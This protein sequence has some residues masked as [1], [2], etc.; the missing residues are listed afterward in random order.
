MLDISNAVNGIVIHQ[1]LQLLLSVE[2][3][4][5]LGRL[6]LHRQVVSR[7]QNV[8]TAIEVILESDLLL[9]VSESFIRQ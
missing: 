1:S 4:P 5:A 8:A 7:C 6:G 2:K 3:A 9:T